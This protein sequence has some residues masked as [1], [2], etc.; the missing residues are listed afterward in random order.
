MTEIAKQNLSRTV[1]VRS[2]L[3]I[4]VDGYDTLMISF[5]AP[6]LART[7][8]L[9]PARVG[10]I[11][12][13][14]YLG[15]MI[16][17][18]TMGSLTDRWGRKTLL[19]TALILAAVATLACAT[20]T[21]FPLLLALRLLA[22]IGLGGA[23]PALSAL[24]AEHARKHRENGTVTMMY[25]GYP[26]GAVVGG[27]VTAAMLHLGWRSIF[28]ATGVACLAAAAIAAT[29]PESLRPAAGRHAPRS[30]GGTFTDQFADGRLWPA[31]TL[32]LGLFCLLMLT[33]FLLSWTPTMLLDRS[34]SMRLAAVGPVVLNVGGIV[35]AL[36]VAPFI[37]RIGPFRP[38]AI[39]IA[40]GAL[41]VALL[42]QDLGSAP[43]ILLVMFCAGLC[44]MGGQLNFPA[45]TI[46][47][48]PP[49]VRGTGA[50]WTMGIGRLGSIVGPI[51][52]G[53]L[54][55]AH[56]SFGALFALAACPA[57]IASLAL[58]ASIKMQRARIPEQAAGG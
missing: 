24:T 36:L 53:L 46:A 8:A 6:L 41:A 35:G 50:G 30:L 58:L 40:A 31:L 51:A 16:G 45:M 11:F 28:V 3:I 18:I 20:A 9:S 10:M 33:Y 55:G 48:F 52:G 27:A 23:L 57:L 34:G 4:M 22:G 25:V 47:L 12:S 1:A 39:M 29:L 26:L 49:H 17:A 43:V 13:V 42:G 54:L 32:W 15:A 19:V 14:G 7:F 5:I 37:D 56:L 21:S 44:V 38:I 2:F